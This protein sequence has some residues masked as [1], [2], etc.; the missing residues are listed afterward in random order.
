MTYQDL[1]FREYVEYGRLE[2]PWSL[3]SLLYEG[4]SAL[5]MNESAHFI[6]NNQLPRPKK[7]RL[8]LA[9]MFYETLE[10]DLA[11]GKSPNT[12]KNLTQKLRAFYAW[13]DKHN[14]EFT[15]KTIEAVFIN[16]CDWTL[17]KSRSSADKK[18]DPFDRV[19][20]V[21]GVIDRALNRK[22]KIMTLTRLRHNKTRKKWSRSSDKLNFSDLF[23]FG[24]AL[25]DICTSLN[26]TS[27]YGNLPALL[28]FRSGQ[29]IEL[30]S[31]LQSPE[32]LKYVTLRCRKA[33]K[34][35]ERYIAEKSWRTRF[36]LMNLRIEAEILTFIAQTQMNLAQVMSLP[37]GKFAYQS[38]SSGYHVN[39][40]Y[41][42]RRGGETQFDIF[43]EYRTHFDEYLK[44]RD[45]LYP[46]DDLLFPLRSHFGRS[47]GAS[48]NF[49]SI[50][51]VM[52]KLGI[53][54]FL[55]RELR[56]SKVNWL[57]R[58]SNDPT[59][60]SEMAQHTELTLLTSYERPNHQTALAEISRYH[61]TTDP[62]IAAPG[63]VVCVK[64]DPQATQALPKEAP[65]PDCT[66]PAGCL[67]CI[68]QRDIAEFD[69]VW[70][71]MSYRHLK[72]LELAS[73]RPNDLTKLDHP[74]FLTINAITAKLEA[75]KE[76]GQ[77]IPWIAESMT[78][79]DEGSYHPKWD[80]F[81]KL[82][83]MRL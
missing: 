46:D 23:E 22:Q 66:N 78:R 72:S 65:R 63:P 24:H 1:T 77:F 32:K 34:N 7:S 6:A 50:K 68:H 27:V 4:V 19:V 31:G 82:A 18:I 21:G 53:K 45:S 71:L 20:G 55:P 67:F 5:P 58:K 73:H 3:N 16:W 8:T 54:V 49:Q 11:A 75:F 61:Q 43:S 13:G 64:I 39:R 80:G 15:I 25:R 52:T 81:V 17:E 29:K 62:T 74:A 33:I 51:K 47:S 69:H 40:V 28:N 35:R 12:V 36:P 38:F 37:A 59:L 56:L 9:V 48:Y 2:T 76:D 79:I 10:A 70:S 30:W 42:E 26:E 57:L 83:E 60:T 41:K 44:W 14:Q